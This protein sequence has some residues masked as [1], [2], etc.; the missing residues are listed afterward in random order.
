MARPR[1]VTRRE[2]SRIAGVSDSAISKACG[3]A[4]KL[5]ELAPACVDERIDV[6]HAVRY[7]KKHGRRPPP[8]P[9]E[10]EEPPSD[11][12]PYRPEQDESVASEEPP[13]R[14]IRVA[15]TG[16]EGPQSIEDIER[17]ADMTLREIVNRF[18]SMTAHRDWLDMRKKQVDIHEKELKNR[19]TDG[20]LIPREAVRVH[21]FGVLEELHKRL[22][23]D[24]PK[25]LVRTIYGMAKSGTPVEEA[26][27]DARDKIG[28]LLR[29]VKDKAARALRRKTGSGNSGD[30]ES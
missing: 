19:Q 7:L 4:G 21:V 11:V 26:E 25:N 17:F 13:P 6:D 12:R 9:R 22:L 3:R 14:F 23:Q 28:S 18:G 16:G 2:L 27:R 8:R 30:D 20:E 15:M 10:R 1:L 24:V 29:P 5:G